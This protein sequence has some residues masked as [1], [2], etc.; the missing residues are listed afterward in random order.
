MCPRRSRRRGTGPGASDP[1]VVTQQFLLLL[2]PRVGVP[3]DLQT[4]ARMA[5]T[6]SCRGADTQMLVSLRGL[7]S[8]RGGTAGALRIG[9]APV[10]PPVS[11][12]AI[13]LSCKRHVAG[14]ECRSCVSFR[15]GGG[16]GETR[17]PARLAAGERVAPGIGRA[18]RDPSAMGRHGP[19]GA[20]GPARGGSGALRRESLWAF[21]RGIRG[22]P[23]GLRCWRDR[24]V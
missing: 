10:F 23:P 5:S 19:K 12:N 2:G 3:D 16:G 13:W 4:L 18:G 9:A 1:G 21:S 15:V 24:D 7:A 6:P 22:F 20:K 17:T 8:S 14:D 11:V